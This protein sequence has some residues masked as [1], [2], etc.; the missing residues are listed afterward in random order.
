MVF[1][2]FVLSRTFFA[3]FCFL[4]EQEISIL[5]QHKGKILEKAVRESGIPL[6]KLTKRIN[7][8]RRWIYNA[9]ENPNLSIEYI[10]QIGDII[11]YDFS[12]SLV[13]LKKFKTSALVLT[14]LRSRRFGRDSSGGQFADKHA[15]GGHLMSLSPQ[16]LM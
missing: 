11:H 9:F 2:F 7:K 13:E 16:V 15:F 8:S 6:T 12:E 3:L 10:I 1:I 5:A 4:C 14:E